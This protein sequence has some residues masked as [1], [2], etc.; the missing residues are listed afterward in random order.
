MLS[1]ETNNLTERDTIFSFV[2]RSQLNIQ[3]FIDVLSKERPFCC[4]IVP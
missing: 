3:P 2:S 1:A 4:G